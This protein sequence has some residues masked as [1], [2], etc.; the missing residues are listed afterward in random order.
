MTSLFAL[1]QGTGIF[2]QLPTLS[3]I[4][5]TLS[6]LIQAKKK[7]KRT[8]SLSFNIISGNIWAKSYIEKQQQQQKD[9]NGSPVYH[10]INRRFNNG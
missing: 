4:P 8:D 6:D 5:N 1:T 9:T 2:I 3:L 7:K 10:T